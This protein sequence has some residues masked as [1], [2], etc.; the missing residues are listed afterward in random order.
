MMS[1]RESSALLHRVA[2]TR[3]SRLAWA[4]SVVTLTSTLMLLALSDHDAASRDAD[5]HAWREAHALLTVEL[6][7]AT[8]VPRSY[9]GLS[10]E[11][12]ALAQFERR[13]AVFQRV[14]SSLHARG[15]GPFVLRIG[16]DSAD[17][18]FW[19][20]RA[21]PPAPWAIAL[22]P[23]WLHRLSGVVERAHL[24]LILDLN[25]VTG[26]PADAGAL[27]Q[28]AVRGLP[29]GSVI[30]FEIGNEPDIY[31]RK[32]WLARTTSTGLGVRRPPGDLAV[33][34]LPTAVTS[35]IY[36][37]D[38]GAYARA[39]AQAAPGVP[40]LGPALA[41]PVLNA[42]WIS[43]LIAASGLG[44]VSV[45]R[46]AFSGC[47]KPRSHRYPTI[48]KLLSARAS[49]GVAD[50]LGGAIRLA[51]GAGLKLRLT[52]L[53]S[54]DCGG[55]PG[56]SN[57]FAT[58]LWAPDALFQMIRAG[59]NGV[60][61]HVRPNAINAAFSID[62]RGLDARPLLY[63][64][65]LFA[66][67]LGPNAQLLPVRVHGGAPS[68]LT[69]WAV[70]VR[71]GGLHVLLIDKSRRAVAVAL[72]L[73][74]NAPAQV[75]RLLA[76]SVRST[77]GVTLNGQRLGRDGKWLGRPDGETATPSRGRYELEVPGESAALVEVPAG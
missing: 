4:A 30:G 6:H 2:R 49:A 40:L 23:A 5:G 74:A 44:E 63:G 14:L 58:A 65:I 64:L 7:G 50:D 48:A 51:H 61:V 69:T 71:G 16:G 53:N 68:A 13:P 59:V 56:V 1:L 37:E 52:E 24:R 29:H 73:P 32:A 9:F 72:R 77:S 12:W 27:A 28:A 66:R 38:F 3:V 26:S 67:T 42:R 46:Y 22:T 62:G 39:L 35:A 41:N 75:D 36:D 55:V 57:S 8:Q 45:H 34:P 10:T 43:S 54:V 47:A 31:S 60:N 20:P 21:T 11:Y 76:R 33:A 18:T 15:D 19:D 25:L 17:H 70:R